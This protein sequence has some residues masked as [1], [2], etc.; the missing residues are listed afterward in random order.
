MC[1]WAVRAPPLSL[2]HRRSTFFR[3]VSQHDTVSDKDGQLFVQQRAQAWEEAVARGIAHQFTTNLTDGL[4]FAWDLFFARSPPSQEVV[5]RRVT[6]CWLVWVG[7]DWQR[8]GFYLR[9]R[10][11]SQTVYSHFSKGWR[12]DDHL[13]ERHLLGGLSRLGIAA[14]GPCRI[15]GGGMQHRLRRGVKRKK[16][17]C[18]R[19][20]V[21]MRFIAM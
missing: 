4:V 3:G 15:A 17:E 12:W 20:V 14:S 16:K 2:P 5:A 18:Y 10:D 9:F 6:E 11:G 7:R 13:L 19:H 1:P 21:A 8:V